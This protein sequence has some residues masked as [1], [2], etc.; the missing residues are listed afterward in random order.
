MN[1]LLN[2]KYKVIQEIG[3]GSIGRVFLCEF[4]DINRKQIQVAVK[5]ISDQTMFG[6]QNKYLCQELDIIQMLINQ[7]NDGNK[8]DNV[9]Q[10]YEIF[11]EDQYYYIVSEFCQFG[12]LYQYLSRNYQNLS[13]Q[14]YLD[15]VIQIAQGIQYLHNINLAHRD[16]KPEN[17]LIKYNKGLQLVI[18]DFGV[19]SI[20]NLKSTVGTIN[21]MA[22]EILKLQQNYDKAVDIWSLGCIIF[23]IIYNQQLFNGQAV[24]QVVSQIR[25]FQSYEKI[26]DRPV[27]KDLN[28]IIKSCLSV[29]V[30]Q[31]PS[32]QKILSR[33]T[34]LQD[35][36]KKEQ[37]QYENQD[38][39]QSIDESNRYQE[40]DESKFT[41]TNTTIQTL[42]FTEQDNHFEQERAIQDK[43]SLFVQLITKY[44]QNGTISAQQQK[45]FQ[46][47]NEEQFVNKGQIENFFKESTNNQSRDRH[48]YK[49]LVLLHHV[50][51]C[52]VIYDTQFIQEV[53]KVI[54]FDD[55]QK[56][57]FYFC[58]IQCA[59]VDTDFEKIDLFFQLTRNKILQQIVEKLRFQDLKLDKYNIN[60][61]LQSLTKYQQQPAFKKYFLQEF[62]SSFSFWQLILLPFI[63]IHLIR[64]LFQI[65]FKEKKQN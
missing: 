59:T 29:D 52:Y 23:E 64:G 22:P 37:F 13:R 16:L 56:R 45:Q 48:E 32:I 51:K 17:I 57:Y 24:Q 9:L 60:E 46:Q 44:F 1:Q 39:N 30:E 4:E 34:E 14:N 49:A 50:L 40:D 7:I 6:Q 33:L 65:H 25:K 61:V 38:E 55:D 43:Q 42:N 47:N 63:L 21:Y 19:S 36:M 35:K 8:C 62:I 53:E 28:E 54:N 5:Q 10:C 41:L 15:I 20:Q 2:N 26:D 12:D 18:T 58:L 27:I 11:K 3:N 31:R